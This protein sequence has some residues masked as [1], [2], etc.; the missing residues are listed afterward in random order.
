MFQSLVGKLETLYF[1]FHGYIICEFQSL[2]GKLETLEYYHKTVVNYVFQSLVGKLE[3]AATRVLM[4]ILTNPNC[5]RIAFCSYDILA[6]N[7][8]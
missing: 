2:V 6:L 7:A 5:V 4:S 8:G 3:T 1:L